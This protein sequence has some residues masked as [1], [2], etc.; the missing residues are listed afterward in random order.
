MTEF[1]TNFSFF[2]LVGVS[3]M[4]DIVARRGSK[5]SAIKENNDD[6]HDIGESLVSLV[7]A[8]LTDPN[9]SRISY[10]WSFLTAW[11]V[12]I[13]IIA[14][15]LESCD[16]PNQYYHRAVDRSRYYFLLTAPQYWNVYIA[17]MVPLVI[18]AVG[19]IFTLIFIIFGEENVELKKKLLKDRLEMFLFVCDIIGV[20]PFF[21]TATYL[22]PHGVSVSQTARLVMT[23][24]EL[25]ITN[26]VLRLIKDV[27]AIRAIRIA[28]SRS[29]EHL[30]LP[31]FFFLL[32]NI[33]AGVFLYFVEPCYDVNSCPWRDLF[34]SS[35]YSVVTMTTSKSPAAVSMH[36]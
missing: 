34:Q 31:L 22:R 30:V 32:F 3:I 21:I 35:F 1:D 29:T 18:D 28:L 24:M 10:I 26:R 13:R 2:S 4:N 8:F 14:I 11:M 12:I 16:G 6:D 33:T 25:M 19:R 5:P 7:Y 27:P 17:C 15:G 20:I 9:T 23:I 36:I